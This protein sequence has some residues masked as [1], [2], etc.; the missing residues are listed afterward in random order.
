[1]QVKAGVV[2]VCVDMQ[3]KAS[4]MSRLFLKEMGRHY[5]VTPTSYLELINTFKSLLHTQRMEV[6]ELKTRYENGLT[7]LLET[8]SQ[9]NAMQVELEELQPKLKEATIATDKLLE[10]I[11]RDTVVAN[12][13]KA[14]VQKDEEVCN[15]Q[16]AEAGQ[17]KAS[18][19]AD[20]AEAIPVLEAAIKAL[21]SLDKSSIVEVGFPRC[22]I[23]NI[24]LADLTYVSVC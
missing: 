23:Y 18:C 4:N 5:Y 21:A 1:L 22:M 2:D 12:E 13:K 7:K 24:S 6:L 16:A 17:M 15:I 11:A 10:V 3:E 9:V 20:L 19:E 8:A 14:V